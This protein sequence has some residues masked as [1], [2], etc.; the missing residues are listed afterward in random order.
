MLMQTLS[1]CTREMKTPLVFYQIPRDWKVSYRIY[2]SIRP[3]NWNLSVAHVY[4][5]AKGSINP[6]GNDQCAETLKKQALTLTIT[7]A[8]A[9]QITYAP[10][11][12]NTIRFR[13]VRVL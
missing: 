9:E 11:E 6:P 3:G 12:S 2:V 7:R 13:V 10:E 5:R 4:A 8:G 1:Q